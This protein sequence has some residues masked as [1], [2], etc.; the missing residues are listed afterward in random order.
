MHKGEIPTKEKA[1][2]AQTVLNNFLQQNCSHS[3][4]DI[5]K[6]DKKTNKNMAQEA[7]DIALKIATGRKSYL[8]RKPISEAQD[9]IVDYYY[10]L[11]NQQPRPKP[12]M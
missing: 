5:D 10:S 3:K 4:I 7:M 1:L 12:S 2:V 11:E 9:T 8:I 6:A